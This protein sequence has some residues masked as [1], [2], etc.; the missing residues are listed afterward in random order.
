MRYFIAQLYNRQTTFCS[1]MPFLI[2]QQQINISYFG[3]ISISDTQ[4]LYFNNGRILRRNL[5][6][7]FFDRF[8]IIGGQHVPSD[9]KISSSYYFVYGYFTSNCTTSLLNTLCVVYRKHCSDYSNISDV[10]YFYLFSL[11]PAL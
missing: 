10:L 7:Q 9:I 8:F 1:A 2:F 5:Y 11:S 3:L 6:I 4:L